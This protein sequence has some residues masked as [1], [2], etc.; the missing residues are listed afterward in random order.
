MAD[1]DDRLQP[2]VSNAAI[3]ALPVV[4]LGEF[5][6][7]IIGSRKRSQ[8][9]QWLNGTANQYLVLPVDEATASEYA[10]VRDELRLSDAL[11]RQTMLGSPRL[12][13][14]TEPVLSRDQHFDF[15]PW[16]KQVFW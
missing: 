11:F 3:L 15:V 16:L 9:E 12:R 13:G 7:G 2:I 8:Y 6:F 1:G 4:V 14:S 10:N 5:R